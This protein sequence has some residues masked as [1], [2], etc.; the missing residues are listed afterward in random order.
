MGADNSRKTLEGLEP[1]AQF[2]SANENTSLTDSD[3]FELI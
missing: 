1:A 3:G 2:A